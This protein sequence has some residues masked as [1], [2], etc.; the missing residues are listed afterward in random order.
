LVF[1]LSLPHIGE[2][3]F[4]QVDFTVVGGTNDE[5]FRVD[6]EGIDVFVFGTYSKVFWSKLEHVDFGILRAVWTLT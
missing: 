5:A 4:P 2:V 1:I 3:H 6:R